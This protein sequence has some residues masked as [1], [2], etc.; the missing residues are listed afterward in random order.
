MRKGFVITV[1]LLLVAVAAWELYQKPDSAPPPAGKD[2]IAGNTVPAKN[3]ADQNEIAP[4]KPAGDKEQG[5]VAAPQTGNKEAAKSSTKDP[6]PNSAGTNDKA[7]QQTPLNAAAAI[8]QGKANGE[9]MWLLFRSETCPPCREMKKVFDQLQ[10][11]YQGKVRFV[12]I[13]VDD[14]ENQQLCEEWKIY[15]IPATFILDN[16]GQLSYEN[17]GFFPVEDLKK[18]LDRVVVK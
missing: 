3:P 5:A 11:E 7:K 17:V 4:G 1:V 14:E 8:E 18:E 2:T 15:Y 9:S 16:K 13:D 10:P 6:K 12:S